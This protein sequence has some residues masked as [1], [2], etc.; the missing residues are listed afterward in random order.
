MEAMT[1]KQIGAAMRKA[2]GQRSIREVAGAINKQQHAMSRYTKSQRHRIYKQ[3]LR[4]FDD[5]RLGTGLCRLFWEHTDCGSGWCSI[6]PFL[7]HYA[8]L[9]RLTEF[10]ELKPTPK[11]VHPFNSVVYSWSLTPQGNA[12][13]RRCLVKCIELTKPTQKKTK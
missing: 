10:M 1:H 13:R 3:A 11:H 7:L 6:Y 9:D 8:S 5:G 12:A 2:R 4:A